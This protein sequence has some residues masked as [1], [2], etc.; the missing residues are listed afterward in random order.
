[1]LRLNAS[2]LKKM[3]FSINFM[4]QA[5]L[6]W[7]GKTVLWHWSS[8]HWSDRKLSS[9]S[10]EK[11]RLRVVICKRKMIQSHLDQFWIES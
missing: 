7:C 5:L 6:K 2:V 11:V 10:W 1:M 8:F 4:I 9:V 3:L